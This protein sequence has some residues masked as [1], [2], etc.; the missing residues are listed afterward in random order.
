MS[1]CSLHLRMSGCGLEGKLFDRPCK[2]VDFVF[3]G[4]EAAIL[5][6]E[7]SSCECAFLALACSQYIYEII[8][9]VMLDT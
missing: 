4:E 8:L 9:R 1:K 5:N 7:L 2:L 3:K 6:V